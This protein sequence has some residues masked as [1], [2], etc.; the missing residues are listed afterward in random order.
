VIEHREALI[1]MLCEAAELEHGIMCQCL[2]AAFSLKKATDEG[3]TEGELAAVT[4]WRRAVA[5]VAT[6]EMLHPP[7]MLMP[8]WDWSTAAGPPGGRISALEPEPDYAA[9]ALPEAGETVSFERT[10]GRCSASATA[11]R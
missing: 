5:H 1:Y 11:S 8:H 6:E 4:R 2:F 3:L 9:V 10:S 7:D